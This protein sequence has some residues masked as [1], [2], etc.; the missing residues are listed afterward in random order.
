MINLQSIFNIEPGLIKK[1]AL[2]DPEVW[3]NLQCTCKKYKD[4]LSSKFDL[5]NKWRIICLK[6]NPHYRYSRVRSN[7]ISD[8]QWF[9]INCSSGKN[10][11]WYR[12]NMKHRSR[13]YS[14]FIRKNQ[15]ILIPITVWVISG[16]KTNKIWYRD[17]K[18]HR[19]GGPAIQK[20][21]TKK[22]YRNGRLHRGD[23]KPAIIQKDGTKRWYRDGKLHRDD[24][25]PAIIQKKYLQ[26]Y[27]TKKWYR[28]GRLHRDDGPAIKYFDGRQEW[29]RDGKRHRGDDKPAFMYHIHYNPKG[30]HQP[31][32]KIYEKWYRDGKL[33][34][35]GGPAVIWYNT[36]TFWYFNRK[37]HDKNNP[38]MLWYQNNKLHRL[39][40]PAIIL[41]N[42]DKIWYFEGSHHR[43]NGPSVMH[44]SGK[45]RWYQYGN[46]ICENDNGKP[47]LKYL[48]KIYGLRSWR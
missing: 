29:Y 6:I 15:N 7:N 1:I 42:G 21:G 24:D 18:F 32:K 4:Y 27:D 31:Y 19:E 40:G 22:W 30:C 17:G 9:N 41:A 26:R 28:D 45:Y 48:R 39:D 34:K 36:D 35:V 11:K 25:K 20:N 16:S 37:L 10:W 14:F 12:C 46:F 5:H 23:D 38:S 47:T 8:Q 33:H 2:D 3:F 43:D 13:C 44:A